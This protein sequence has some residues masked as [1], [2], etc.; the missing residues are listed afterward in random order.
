[1]HTQPFPINIIELASK[2]VLVRPKVVDKGKGK[3][4]VIGDPRMSN[5]SQ[6]GIAQK[7][8]D[9]KTDMSRGTGGQAQSSSRAKLPDSSITDCP[10]PASGRSGAHADGP[11]DSA[12]Q[13]AHG[14]R[15]QPPHKARKGMQG[16]STYNTHGRLVKP[17]HTF[18]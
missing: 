3:N 5:I 9:R 11:V 13:S 7:A 18:D 17:D 16:Q 14:Q 1:V 2:K 12:G 6:E 4:I 10:T 15:C 8:L